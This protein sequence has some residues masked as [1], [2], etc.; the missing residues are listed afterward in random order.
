[1]TSKSTTDREFL[2]SLGLNADGPALTKA[3]TE[4]PAPEGV[5]P[6]TMPVSDIV[7]DP[8]LLDGFSL[9][10]ERRQ[11]AD[12]VFALYKSPSKGDRNKLL[13]AEIGK[14]I[15]KV[16]DQRKGGGLI[17]EKVKAS[18][19]ERA[20]AKIIASQGITAEDLAALIKSK[21]A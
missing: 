13:W 2:M 11:A 18:A 9:P 21:E 3:R 7:F 1:M 12:H 8:K 6:H 19:E 20:L 4:S 10:S 5:D 14:F 15:T 17:K 16:I